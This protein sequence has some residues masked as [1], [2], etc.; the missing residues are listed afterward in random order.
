M[1]SYVGIASG[2]FGIAFGVSPLVVKQ[3]LKVASDLLEI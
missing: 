2:V 3:P 1:S